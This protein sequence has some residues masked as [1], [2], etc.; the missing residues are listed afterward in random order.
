[1]NKADGP[2]LAEVKIAK[3]DDWKVSKAKVSG[4]QPGVQNLVVV[5]KGENPV[6]IDWVKFE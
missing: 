1:M 4:V 2:V 5:S 6:E 3:S